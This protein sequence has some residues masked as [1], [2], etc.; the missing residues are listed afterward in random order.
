VGENSA[1][2]T[3]KEERLRSLDQRMGRKDG[4]KGGGRRAM[5][6]NEKHHITSKKPQRQERRQ[7]MY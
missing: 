3:T 7:E 4:V 6:G 1:T 5:G 2:T